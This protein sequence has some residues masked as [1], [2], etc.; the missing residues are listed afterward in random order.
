MPLRGV[1]ADDLQHAAPIGVP[2]LGAHRGEAAAN[3]KPL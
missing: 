1:M 2:D 3:V